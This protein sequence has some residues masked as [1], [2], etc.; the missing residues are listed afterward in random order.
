MTYLETQ[1]AEG[2]EFEACMLPSDDWR[3]TH[4]PSPNSKAIKTHSLSPVEI[5]GDDALVNLDRLRERIQK[6]KGDGFEV[7]YALEVGV[8]TFEAGG[9]VMQS[10]V[11]PAEQMCYMPGAT[12]FLSR[13][14]NDI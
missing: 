10:R 6:A 13:K 14:K 2:F 8:P 4:Q 5:D 9:M 3:V 12:T 1:V 7:I 11:N